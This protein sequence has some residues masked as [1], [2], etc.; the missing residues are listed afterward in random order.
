M[1]GVLLIIVIHIPVLFPGYGHKCIL[2]IHI[3]FNQLPVDPFR[4]CFFCLLA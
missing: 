4:S 3:S 1:S 2:K